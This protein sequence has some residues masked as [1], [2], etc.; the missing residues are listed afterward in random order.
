MSLAQTVHWPWWVRAHRMQLGMPH[1]AQG[2]AW[3][4]QWRSVHDEQVK[5]SLGK[6]CS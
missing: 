6:T 4:W 1:A 5:V 3:A 2:V